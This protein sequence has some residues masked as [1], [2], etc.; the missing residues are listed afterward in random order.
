VDT[1][2]NSEKIHF[3]DW[4][5]PEADQSLVSAQKPPQL[6]IA[7]NGG[8][9]VEG[10]DELSTNFSHYDLAR[11]W[12]QRNGTYW[13]FVHKWQSWMWFNG[14]RW[15]RDERRR[16]NSEIIEYMRDV[17]DTWPSVR[18]LS[19]N[20]QRELE[21]K[22]FA[23]NVRD[24]IKDLREINSIPDDWDKD[25]FLLGVPGGVIDLRTGEMRKAKPEDFI[26]KQCSVAPMKGAHGETE[27]YIRDFLCS[28]DKDKYSYLQRLCGYLLYGARPEQ[29]FTFFF[30]SGGNGKGTFTQMIQDIMGSYAMTCTADL[31]IINQRLSASNASDE[32]AQLNN[33]RYVIVDE[34]PKGA[35]LNEQRI[36]AMTGGGNTR[37]AAKYGHS[38]EFK[39]KCYIM[40]TANDKPSV[41]STGPNMQRRL[42]LFPAL[43]K[44]DESKKDLKLKEK[45]ASGYP[46]VLQWMIEGFK[47][48]QENGLNPP[49][50]MREAAANYLESEDIVGD[51]FDDRCSHKA[52][53]KVSKAIA[54][55][56]FRDWCHDQGKDFVMPD[57]LFYGELETKGFKFGR[58][59]TMRFIEGLEIKPKKSEAPSSWQDN[60]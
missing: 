27:S 8:A 58:S 11:I 40:M 21:G 4:P 59:S 3:A 45:L 28:G 15:E 60:D 6:R 55:K 17:H 32:L 41:K 20:A 16:I 53:N 54:Y 31:F 22:P 12:A 26:T 36:L 1:K 48:W 5:D 49:L 13:R 35:I 37:A 57:R 19:V 14:E 33:V 18:H 44:F 46:Y 47:L 52:D 23:G 24:T 25:D 7:T 30:G 34:L 51:W 56:D 9:P 42:H 29:C 43:N 38:A 50:S 39:T 2:E 10:L